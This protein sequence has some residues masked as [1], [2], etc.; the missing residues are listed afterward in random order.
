MSTKFSYGRLIG[1]AARG[2]LTLPGADLSRTR[3]YIHLLERLEK[4]LTNMGHFRSTYD[5]MTAILGTGTCFLYG[6][7]HCAIYYVCTG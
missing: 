3:S 4:G 1:G 7:V 2:I 5:V 6:V